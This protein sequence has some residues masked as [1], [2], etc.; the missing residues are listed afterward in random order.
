[1]NRGRSDK[2]TV[3]FDLNQPDYY[4]N[5]LKSAD[6]GPEK[7]TND[8]QYTPQEHYFDRPYN[9]TAPKRTYL[10]GNKFEDLEEV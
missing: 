5:D 7:Y 3:Q 10:S 6:L 8:E 9:F 4:Y 1:M 2:P